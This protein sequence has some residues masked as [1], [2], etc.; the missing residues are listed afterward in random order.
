MKSKSVRHRTFDSQREL[1]KAA[2]YYG[3]GVGMIVSPLL[4][5]SLAFSMYFFE[6]VDIVTALSYSFEIQLLFGVGYIIFSIYK[7][8]KWESF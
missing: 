6:Y 3:V 4:V 8:K 2:N 5:I 1:I 7:K